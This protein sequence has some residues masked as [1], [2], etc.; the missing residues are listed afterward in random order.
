MR[1]GNIG[2]IAGSLR[3]PG[4]LAA[5]AVVV[6]RRWKRYCRGEMPTGNN[7]RLC[8]NSRH[9]SWWHSSPHSVDH[10]NRHM[11]LGWIVWVWLSE[12]C[13]CMEHRQ[14]VQLESYDR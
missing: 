3:R 6:V 7:L 2:G 5:A 1:E 8:R 11:S 4:M 10:S 13:D 9:R 12:K 14:D